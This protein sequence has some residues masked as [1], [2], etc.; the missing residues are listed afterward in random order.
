VCFVLLCAL[1]CVLACSQTLCSEC[2]KPFSHSK[3]R[4]KICNACRKGEWE[5]GNENM[6]REEAAMDEFFEEHFLT[7]ET[8]SSS[9]F[10]SA[11]SSSS[12]STA[13][14]N[15][16]KHGDRV[17]KSRAVPDHLTLLMHL[18]VFLL[19]ADVFVWRPMAADAGAM[20]AQRLRAPCAAAR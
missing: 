4:G 5:E 14:A 17:I 8:P 10:S 18:H 7:P 12:S 15:E 6:M 13:G 19:L 2:G 20:Q 11:S 16:W 9:H 1:L 3:S